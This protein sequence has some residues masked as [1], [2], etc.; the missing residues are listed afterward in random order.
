M[1]VIRNKRLIFGG[2]HHRIRHPPTA[3]GIAPISHV[4]TGSTAYAIAFVPA[5]GV[6]AIGQP[7]LSFRTSATDAAGVAMLCPRAISLGRTR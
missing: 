2:T 6:A 7:E 5:L 1:A 4:R 3:C